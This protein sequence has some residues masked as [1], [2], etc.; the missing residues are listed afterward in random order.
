MVEVIDDVFLDDGGE[1]LVS[2]TLLRKA[3]LRQEMLKRRASLSS[4][5]WEA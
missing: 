5:E 4:S 2:S 1:Q 3:A